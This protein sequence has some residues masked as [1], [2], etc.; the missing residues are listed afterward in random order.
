[1]MIGVC[2]PVTLR[3]RRPDIETVSHEPGP[4]A[5]LYRKKSESRMP[6][7]PPL[8]AANLEKQIQRGSQ[9]TKSLS[10]REK[11]GPASCVSG[12]SYIFQTTPCRVLKSAVDLSQIPSAEVNLRC[13]QM[14]ASMHPQ[15]HPRV[16]RDPL[17]RSKRREER[18][19]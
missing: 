3:R 13:T 16:P 9:G 12:S 7:P 15:L 1:M 4:I 8:S 19:H 14:H 10:I 6:E 11:K 5:T 17:R 18:C 2:T